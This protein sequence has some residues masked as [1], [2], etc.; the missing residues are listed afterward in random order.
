MISIRIIRTGSTDGATQVAVKGSQMG[1]QFAQINKPMN[2]AQQTI[3]REPILQAKLIKQLR[4]IVLLSFPSYRSPPMTRHIEGNHGIAR[5]S[6]DFFNKIRHMETF[7]L[8]SA[9][10]C[11]DQGFCAL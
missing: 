9:I 10:C 8:A 6:T 7:G 1:A 5:R 2:L 11:S 4:L 3:A